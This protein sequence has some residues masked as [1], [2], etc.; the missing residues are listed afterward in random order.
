MIIITT[1]AMMT[2]VIIMLI[3]CLIFR[4]CIS[5]NPQQQHQLCI[6]C[7]LRGVFR[8]TKMKET[9]QVFSFILFK[10]SNDHLLV[11]SIDNSADDDDVQL[12]LRFKICWNWNHWKLWWFVFILGNWY[13]ELYFLFLMLNISKM[14]TFTGCALR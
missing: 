4:Y 10:L 13:E 9:K 7:L 11:P 1:I 3:I 12:Q 8:Y 6:L 14:K 5:S 2:I